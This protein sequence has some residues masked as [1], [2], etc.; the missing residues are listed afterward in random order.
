MS[1]N[2]NIINQSYFNLENVKSMFRVA[3]YR[4]VKNR[5]DQIRSV[6]QLCPTL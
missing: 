5:L 2:Q 1:E 6:A 4:T 3:V